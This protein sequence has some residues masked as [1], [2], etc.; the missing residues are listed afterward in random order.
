MREKTGKFQLTSIIH[1]LIKSLSIC[2]KT[3]KKSTQKIE[4][5]VTGNLGE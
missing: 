1:R 3:A 5:Y 2:G 4:I